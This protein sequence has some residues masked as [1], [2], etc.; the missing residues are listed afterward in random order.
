MTDF[1]A[2]FDERTWATEPGIADILPTYYFVGQG[3]AS[4]VEVAYATGSKPK[5]SDI[6]EAWN[7]RWN[8]RAN[9]VLLVVDHENGMATLCGLRDSAVAVRMPLASAE[10]IATAFLTEPNPIT[11]ERQA[12][13]ALTSL[14][15]DES[16]GLTNRGLFSAQELLSGVPGRRDWQEHCKKSDQLLSYKGLE[17]LDRMGWKTSA[18]GSSAQR[19][20]VDNEDRALAVVLTT[21][22]RFERRSNR[23]GGSPVAHGLALAAECDI[24][25]LI[26]ISGSRLRIHSSRPDTG[27]GKKG[28]TETYF[29]LETSHLDPQ[30]SGFLTLIFSPTALAAAG[31]I[32][33]VLAA[34]VEHA[35]A[36]GVRLRERIYYDVMPRLTLD[37]LRSLSDED[38]TA[39]V[40]RAYH[41]SMTILFR[42]LFVA[43]AEDRALLPH[44]ENDEYTKFSLK[45]LAQK[46]TE[47]G[48][49]A[50]HSDVW[51]RL[52]LVWDSID[53]GND[54][55]EIP[56]YNGG[57]FS[58]TSPMGL[59]VEELQ[60]SDSQLTPVLKA[61][62]V[63]K[64]S[65][66]TVGPVDFRSLS[67]REFGTIYEGLLESSLAVADVDLTLD[68][69]DV[70]RPA[71]P[72]DSVVVKTGEPYFHNTSGKRKSTGSFF[73]KAFAV[74]HLLD[75]SLE[76][77]IN[78]HLND[79]EVLLANNNEAGAA[80]KFFDFRVADM[81]MGSAHFLVA[82]L[83]RIEARFRSFLSVHQIGPVTKELE[84]LHAVA[85]KSVGTST[86]EIDNTALLRRQIA[87]H[88]LYGM[89][90][91]EM[92]VE[93]GKLALW[94]HTFVPGLPM[95]SLNHTLVHGNSL[96]GIASL[97]ELTEIFT[98][99]AKGKKVITSKHGQSD[100][101]IDAIRDDL[102]SARQAIVRIGV[103]SEAT[104][105]EVHEAQAAYERALDEARSANAILD[106]ALA[107]RLGEAAYPMSVEDAVT[108]G[109]S[110]STQQLVSELNPIHFPL[111]FP[112]VFMRDR[113][114]W[115]CVIG[116]PPWEEITVAVDKFWQKHS[117]GLLGL[118]GQAYKDRLTQLQNDRPDLVAEYEAEQVSAH[119][120][121]KVLLCGQFPQL[122]TGDPDLY[123]AFSW[124]MWQTL[125]QD[126]YM[127]VV[128]PRSILQVGGCSQ[129]RREVLTNGEFSSIVTL[130][131]DKKWV[132]DDVEARYTF[133]L[134][135]AR[136]TPDLAGVIRLAGPFYSL[137]EFKAGRS[138]SAELS[139]R[140]ILA[141]ED[142][143]LP[144]LP[145]STG[146]RVIAKYLEHAPLSAPG[147]WQFQPVRE[148]DVS[149]DRAVYS[150]RVE[151]GPNWPTL[152][153][154]S[155]SY[156]NPDAGD[157]VCETDAQK[158][159]AHLK[160]K[161][162][163]QARLARSAFHGLT[164][165]QLSA[166]ETLPCFRPRIAYSSVGRNTDTRTMRSGIVPP[167]VFLTNAAPYLYRKAGDELDEAFL[168]AVMST[169]I[170]DWYVRRFVEMNVQVGFVSSCPVPRPDRDDP[171][172]KELATLSGRLAAVDDRYQE[173]AAACGA[174][175]GHIS[176]E[177][178]TAMTNRIEAL[179]A[180]AYGL[181]AADVEYIYATFHKGWD[182]SNQLRA[183]LEQYRSSA[184]ERV[185][186]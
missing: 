164:P 174:E 168:A 75:V 104:K 64:G 94:I 17:L 82:A 169:V 157:I 11:A 62:L 59:V 186:A 14:A 15:N 105:A 138:G 49:G 158:A 6:R 154:A 127:G 71:G 123:K 42:L 63:D 9:A 167:N 162:W 85:A 152:T 136:K 92:A 106:G 39:A 4:A 66:G 38:S 68:V 91:N 83:D 34:S 19:L 111:A 69:N 180:L 148:F 26:L 170:F 29:E 124:R 134:V 128:F 140:A 54:A 35:A 131:N 165:A 179:T 77:A 84:R 130:G 178:S 139:A 41:C 43:Y 22:E 96:T 31:T 89:D 107:V 45:T 70:Y 99:P 90:V 156:W 55:W 80:K 150:T 122:G 141:N 171:V 112:E 175:T 81:T 27:V 2:D 103:T 16:P 126:G 23:L 160:K 57:L 18:Y 145:S 8:K 44:G 93:L 56:A 98:P 135:A 78:R 10:R 36:L 53:N 51:Q 13:E 86:L 117:P 166:D 109:R 149:T 129:W 37:V 60:L 142:V 125:R 76:P 181:S 114:G 146:V 20:A 1:L 87:R 121:R 120:L 177:E 143:A 95:S 21:D 172:W 132:F 30:L 79:V 52:R 137:D 67:V 119:R 151:H 5:L 32:E 102:H 118:K 183:V 50:E 147:A 176:P 72:R 73:T 163:N 153:G 116:N 110:G 88:C 97:E 65:D 28:Q 113:P 25:W 33:Q 47:D 7:A 46:L 100:Y 115:D 173:W 74:E 48:I 58:T 159:I 184:Q 40:E 108:I 182:Y 24:P 144:V 155:F 3:G 101:I 161:R 133:A 12:E 61:L 185:R